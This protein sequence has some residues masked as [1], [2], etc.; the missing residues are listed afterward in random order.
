MTRDPRR[1]RLASMK[2][3]RCICG[4]VLTAETGE[5]LL[6]EVERHLD[7]MLTH[8][9]LELAGREAQRSIAEA[10]PGGQ[11]GPPKRQLVKEEPWDRFESD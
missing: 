8:C 1:S 2:S 7:E 10:T 5:A 9:F 4:R 11:L 6:T 3:L